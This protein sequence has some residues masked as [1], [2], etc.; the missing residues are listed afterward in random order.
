MQS[1]GNSQGLYRLQLPLPGLQKLFNQIGWWK[2]QR[3]LSPHRPI[4]T[5]LLQPTN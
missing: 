3:P 5:S 2:V 4:S 1:G